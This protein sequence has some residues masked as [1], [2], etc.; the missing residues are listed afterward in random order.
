MLVNQALLPWARFLLVVRL[1][2]RSWTDPGCRRGGCT[3]TEGA[4]TVIAPP[5]RI[6]IVD[7]SAT[8]RR[9]V[10]A[11]LQRAGHTAA[12]AA[13]G[14]LGLEQVYSFA[15]D[16]VLLDFAMPDMNGIQFLRR[17]DADRR[18]AEVVGVVLMCTRGDQAPANDEALRSVGVIDTI[19]KPFS[20][21][22]LLAVLQHSI[23]KH[24]R[25][26]SFCD[27]IRVEAALASLPPSIPVGADDLIQESAAAGVAAFT[28]PRATT[29]SGRRLVVP[30]L[31]QQPSFALPEGVALCGDLTAIGLPE[32]LQLLKFQGQTGLLLVDAAGLRF[33]MGI[34]S[35]CV[36]ALSARD[37]DGGP[38]RRGDHWLGRYFVV[39]G[40]I[41]VEELQQELTMPALGRPIGE[42]LVAAGLVTLEELNFVLHEQT[43]ELTVELLRARRGVFAWSPGEGRLP[44]VVVRPG[45]G[46]DQLIFEA[47]RKV[48]EWGVIESE[49]P[50]FE[51]RFAI[52]SNI[53][54]DTGLSVEEA[55]L[56]RA[57]S[58]GPLLVRDLV[59]CSTQHP[60]DVCR[61]LYRLAVLKRVRRIDDGDSSKLLDDEGSMVQV[62]LLSTVPREVL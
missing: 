26:S 6:L 10:S 21:D 28:V 59:K 25:R 17:L 1:P 38:A 61:I 5:L 39:A 46:I 34:E 35:G 42:R 31:E 9:V 30:S 22:A 37:P 14:E 7:D 19:T 43:R 62:P 18:D 20:P 44:A 13:S 15:P 4:L 3:L 12:A 55:T 36:V 24:S 23:E 27:P 47:L 33:Q 60:F 29:S 11:V 16:I 58:A 50:S 52:Y 40:C 54:D 49:V 53:V 32:V 51:A 48:D 8:V 56:L 41:S 2:R 57:L 45:C